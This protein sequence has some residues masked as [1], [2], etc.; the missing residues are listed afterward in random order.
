MC[1]FQR[2]NLKYLFHIFGLIFSMLFLAGGSIAQSTPDEHIGLE[3]LTDEKVTQW[4]EKETEKTF[5]EIRKMANYDA[6][7]KDN[8]KILTQREYNIQLPISVGEFV[9]NYYWTGSQP[10]GVWRRATLSEYKKDS[11]SWQTLFNIDAYNRDTNQKWSFRAAQVQSVAI[12]KK[13]GNAPRAMLMLSKGGSDAVVMRE[14]D[15]KTRK[16]IEPNEQGFDV[17]QAKGWADWWSADELIIATDFGPGTMTDSTYARQLR[18]WK[19]G[20]P[21]AS[22]QMIFNAEASDVS[23]DWKL[24]IA[25]DGQQF[26]LVSRR[27]SF[28]QRTYYLWDSQELKP[29]VVPADSQVS[30]KQGK[31]FI[32]LYSDWRVGDQVF[33]A[34]SLLMAPQNA[35]VQSLS[36]SDF[37]VLFAPRNGSSLLSFVATNDTIVVNELSDLKSRINIHSF[38]S[39]VPSKVLSDPTG[40]GLATIWMHDAA[41]NR[42]WIS[43][44]GF[45]QPPTLSILDASKGTSEFFHKQG[46]VGD[47]NL[48]TVSK[49]AAKSLDGT[50]IPYTVIQPKTSA[51]N[52]NQPT[53]LYGYGG[54]GISLLP[55]YQ[56]FQMVNWLQ[57]G[58]TYVIAHIRGGGDFG[59]E[60][61]KAAKGLK[62]QTGFDDFTAVAQD[63][64]DSKVTTPRNLGIYGASN[65]GLLVSA[66]SVQHPEL[67]GAVVSRVPLTD[68][69]RYTKLLAGASWIEEYG[70][71]DKPEDWTVMQKYSPYQNL[72]PGRALPPTLYITNRND[73]RVHPAHGRKMVA[74]QRALGYPAWLFEASAGGHSGRAT[75]QL[76]AEREALLYTFLMH[77]LSKP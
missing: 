18:L 38:D 34:G 9:Y 48:Y 69:Q 28:F 31:I 25:A 2:G 75:P 3:S 46:P 13:S 53:L 42:L 15:L 68:M 22:A 41:S 77:H 11:P 44:Q 63:L 6:R 73:D 65:G 62:R 50:V 51:T 47:A 4:V 29:L 36:G 7:Y 23:V 14:F 1:K 71:P 40:E 26:L 45:I 19:R 59:I 74:K 8:L 52:Q 32:E 27:T 21:L 5:A 43:H 12:Q 35:L 20:T 70:N 24:D 72:K 17:P 67:F 37:R 64:I 57:Y 61:M 66:V 56:R 54:F 55:E 76:F 30:I 58:G 10:A 49:R 39:A 60:W 16:I 33:A